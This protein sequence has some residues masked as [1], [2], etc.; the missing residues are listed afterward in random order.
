MYFTVFPVPLFF[1]SKNHLFDIKTLSPLSLALFF[2]APRQGCVGSRSMRQPRNSW[3]HTSSTSWI[4]S[5]TSRRRRGPHPCRRDAGRRRRMPAIA[6]SRRNRQTRT[7]RGHSRWSSSRTF[8]RQTRQPP[9][10]RTLQLVS[11]SHPAFRLRLSLLKGLPS[12]RKPI[13]LVRQLGKPHILSMKILITE[14]SLDQRPRGDPD[15][16]MVAVGPKRPKSCD[17]YLFLTEAF[18]FF[19]V[20]V[21]YS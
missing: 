6:K 1:F 20:F 12:L 4:S 13:R 9:R 16:M 7:P 18:F 10:G 19:L 15:V 5:K 3:C 2:S 8:L 11:P 14:L 17:L 21:F